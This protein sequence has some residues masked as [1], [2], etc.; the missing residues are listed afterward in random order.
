MLST[1]YLLVAILLPGGEDAARPAALIAAGDEAFEQMEYALAISSYEAA[2]G[3][4]PEDPQVL[5]RLA[6]TSVCFGESFE[7]ARR[8]ELCRRAEQYARRS[9]AADSTLGEAHTW[10]AGAL[11][12]I[13]LDEGMH[14]QAELSREVLAETGSALALNPRDDAALSIRGSVYRALGNVSWV[15]RK[16][17][18]LLLGGIPEGGFEEAEAALRKAAALAPTVMRHHYELGVLYIDWDRP[19]DARRAFEQAARCPVRVAIDRPRLA[20]ARELLRSLAG[21]SGAE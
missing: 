16:V 5:L 11:G 3:L 19:E 2:L 18:S 9:I 13:A 4:R 6:R 15:K 8:R 20:K 17:A 12:Y 7:D 21:G 14:R 1:L 10:L